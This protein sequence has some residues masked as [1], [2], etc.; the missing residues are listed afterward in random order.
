[1]SYS[2]KSLLG[3]YIGDCISESYSVS[4]GGPWSLD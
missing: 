4:K 3:S 1:M 2:L